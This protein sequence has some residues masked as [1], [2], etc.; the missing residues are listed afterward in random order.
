MHDRR[1]TRRFPLCPRSSKWILRAL[2]DLSCLFPSNPPFPASEGGWANPEIACRVIWPLKWIECWLTGIS[3][4][5]MTLSLLTPFTFPCSIKLHSF[6]SQPPQNQRR[7]LPQTNHIQ[8]TCLPQQNT[9]GRFMCRLPIATKFTII[10]TY[11]FCIILP[12]GWETMNY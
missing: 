7:F 11:S 4:A 12:P 1:S 6:L 2:N 10:N 3:L 8:T 9:C 5:M